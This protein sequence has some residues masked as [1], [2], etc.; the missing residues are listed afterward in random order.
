MLDRVTNQI[1]AGYYA[2]RV[3]NFMV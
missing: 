2:Q 3:G 1:G